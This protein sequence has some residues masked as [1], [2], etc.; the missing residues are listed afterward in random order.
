GTGVFADL[1]EI[2][3]KGLGRQHVWRLTA[4]APASAK[5]RLPFVGRHREPDLLLTAFRRA[6]SGMSA[7]ALISG[8]PGQGKTRLVE[9]FIAWTGDDAQLLRARCRPAGELGARNPLYELLTSDGG[10]A[11]AEDLE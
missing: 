4:L 2:E 10:E 5:A 9:E 8:P 6:K 7:F 1:G 11:S 3:L